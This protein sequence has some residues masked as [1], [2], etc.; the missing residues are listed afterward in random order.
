MISHFPDSSAE[1]V[2]SD[3]GY[4]VEVVGEGLI[5]GK[6]TPIYNYRIF[7]IILL[8][9]NVTNIYQSLFILTS[10]PSSFKFPI[11]KSLHI[12]LKLNVYTDLISQSLK[13]FLDIYGVFQH[14]VITH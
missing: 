6:C 11:D 2:H 13:I 8:H 7:G 4:K 9:R 5:I 3:L 10:P 1:W 14:P 12:V